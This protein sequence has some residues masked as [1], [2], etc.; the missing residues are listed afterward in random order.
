[1]SEL[2]HTFLITR[3]TGTHADVFA[4][5]GLAKLLTSS[6][7]P[8][9]ITEE[10][11]GF[12]VSVLRPENGLKGLSASPGYPFLKTNEKVVVPH[13]AFDPVDYKA[14][15]AKADRIKALRKGKKLKALDAITLEAIEREKP[16]PTWRLL[17][18]LNTLQGDETSNRIHELI[19]KLKPADFQAK[20]TAALH[21]LA[22]NKPS[23]LDWRATSVQLFTPIAAKG[24]SRLKPDSTDRNDKTKDQWTDP[25]IEWLRYQGYFAVACPFFQGPKSEHVRLLCPIPYDISINALTGA[26]DTLRATWLPGDA[27]KLDSLAVLKLAQI[28]IEHSSEYHADDVDPFDDF[29]LAGRSPAKAISG[30]SITHY[31]SLGNAKAV[32][33]MST[34]ALPDW[35]PLDSRNDAKVMLGIL[36]EHQTIVRSLQDNH[37]D[38][39][40]MLIDYRRF[41]QTRGEPAVQMLIHFMGAYA[42]LLLRAWQ[43]GRRLPAFSPENFRR[44]LM[45]MTPPLTEVLD[46]PGFKAIAGAVRRA[47]VSAQAMKAMNHKDYREIRYDL[48]PELRRKSSLPGPKPLIEA[49]SEFISMYN[50]ENARRREM[51]KS[52]PRNV[53]TEEFAA[54][55]ALVESPLGASTVGAMLCAYGTCRE[56]REDEN[57][58]H[59]DKP[60]D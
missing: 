29:P 7:R 10:S 52:A 49:I 26:A 30:I 31:Q 3:S 42:S 60:T 16:R 22:E 33:A 46:N 44:I 35:F 2:P 28:L 1:M 14:E 13:G 9:Q 5:A 8:V 57:D 21:A 24:Y 32:S 20:L 53:T 4:A 55:V 11:T 18:V 47:T 56:P 58:T 36:D 51:G 34:I 45:A 15:K 12:R 25:F 6:G 54:F 50:V 40:G 43:Q 38:E 48:L 17:Q 37:S 39:I 23:G 19:V 27:A 59:T 41:L